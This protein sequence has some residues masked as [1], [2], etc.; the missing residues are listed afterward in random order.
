VWLNFNEDEEPQTRENY[1]KIAFTTAKNKNGFKILYAYNAENYT[2]G[3][4]SDE[5]KTKFL[6]L[7]VKLSAKV[8]Q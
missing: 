4:T 5:I 8:C 6:E 7:G 1:S 2:L 3:D